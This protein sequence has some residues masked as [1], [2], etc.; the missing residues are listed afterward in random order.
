MC[1]VSN[2][3]HL[4]LHKVNVNVCQ[5]HLHVMCKCFGLC[6]YKGIYCYKVPPPSKNHICYIVLD[7]HLKPYKCI[8]FTMF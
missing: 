7:G 4:H 2:F 3:L 6:K 8:L 5:I 1:N